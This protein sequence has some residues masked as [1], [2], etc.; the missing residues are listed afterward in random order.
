MSTPTGNVLGV[1]AMAETVLAVIEAHFAAAAIA[2][3]DRRAIAAGSSVEV[4]W[5]CEQLLVM[6]DSIGWGQAIDL[7]QESP[8]AGNPF[9]AHALR[10][11]IFAVQLV[12]CTP[13]GGNRSTVPTRDDLHAAGLQFMTDAG[14]LSQA[15]VEAVSRLRSGLSRDCVVQAGAIT[16]AGPEGAYHGLQSTIA[17]TVGG[18]A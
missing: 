3:P 9:S 15:L 13:I 1:R 7:A 5:D 12:R 11:A 8:R 14:A 10:H 18:F 17:V 16:P 6:L 4:A 2:L